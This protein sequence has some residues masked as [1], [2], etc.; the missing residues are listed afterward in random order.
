[1]RTVPLGQ[2][3][4][5][6]SPLCFGTLPFSPLQGYVCGTETCPPPRAEPDGRAA[7][8]LARAFELGVN[9]LDTAQL[10]DNYAL[11]RPALATPAGRGVVVASKTYAHTREGALAAVE[12]ARRG[13]G[14]DVIDLFLL[15]EQES[16]HTLRGHAPALEALY[17]LK[18]SGVLRAVGLSTH[19]AEGVWAAVRAGLDVVHPLLNVAGLGGHGPPRPSGSDDENKQ[20]DHPLSVRARMEDAVTAAMD[21][22]LG[23]YIMKALGGG[24]LFRRAQ[25]A[26]EYARRWGHSVALGMRDTDEAEAAAAFFETGVLPP[27][28]NKKPRALHIA[29]WCEGCGRCAAACKSGA[30]EITDGKARLREGTEPDGCENL[31]RTDATGRACVLCGYCGAACPHFCIKVV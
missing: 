15:H 6:V 7:V 13:L 25:E 26:L 20:A 23:V 9:F 30:L 22:G 8:T 31:A 21:A 28:A 1:M 11:I 3:G 14:R 27:L 19:R 10:Y 2:T 5:A 18:A 17:D 12:E 29:D 16:E 24:H 4:I